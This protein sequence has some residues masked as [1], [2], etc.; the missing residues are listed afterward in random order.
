[1]ADKPSAVVPIAQLISSHKFE[2]ALCGV[3][4]L[5][6][7][8]VDVVGA[9]FEPQFRRVWPCF[10][11]YLTAKPGSELRAAMLGL[12]GRVSVCALQSCL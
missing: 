12:I 3:M 4:E 1:M 6:A 10:V 9:E 8:V 11:N 5:L 7:D 2:N